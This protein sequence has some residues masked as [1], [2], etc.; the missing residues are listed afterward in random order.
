MINAKFNAII[1]FLD[2]SINKH[3]ILS[4]QKDYL[5]LPS[6]NIESNLDIDSCLDHIVST[7]IYKDESSLNFRLTDVVLSEI[8]EIY[9]VVFINYESKIKDGFL[10]D[11]QSS[12]T[13]LP[14]NAKKILALL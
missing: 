4:S 12:L 6:I 9:Y 11:I 10:L 2:P 8:L 7:K 3:R 5:E 1:L 14:L 13:G